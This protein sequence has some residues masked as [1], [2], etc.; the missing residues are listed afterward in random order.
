MTAPSDLPLGDLPLAAA[1]IPAGSWRV[2]PD[3]ASIG[4]GSPSK[5]PTFVI[6]RPV[7]VDVDLL[8]VTQAGQGMT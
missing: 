6:G 7:Q 8:V 2:V 3:A 1:D 4:P 5:V